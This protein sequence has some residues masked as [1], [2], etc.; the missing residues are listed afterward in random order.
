MALL[1]C[2]RVTRPAALL[3]RVG[4]CKNAN[5]TPHGP[6]RRA[7]SQHA[8]TPCVLSNAALRT[9][10]HCEPPPSRGA[11]DALHAW[12]KNANSCPAEESR[13]AQV[14]RWMEQCSYIAASRVGRSGHLLTGSMDSL[15]F[16]Q[17]TRV[18]DTLYITAQARGRP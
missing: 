8:L 1:N 7:G 3:R 13:G 18:G 16:A 9:A 17:P 10:N 2:L 14:M 4:K 6:A 5:N 15:A 11:G 12:A